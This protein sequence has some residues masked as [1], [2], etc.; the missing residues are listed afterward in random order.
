MSH[1]MQLIRNMEDVSKVKDI[2]DYFE[3]VST[4]ADEY[5]RN[6][7]SVTVLEILGNDKEIIEKVKP[8]M[9]PVTTK[10]QREADLDLGRIIE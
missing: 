7:F 1:V 3:I 8:Y 2:F 10:Y 9:G 6:T 4:N 5:L